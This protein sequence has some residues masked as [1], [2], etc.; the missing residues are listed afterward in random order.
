MNLSEQNH[1]GGVLKKLLIFSILFAGTACSAHDIKRFVY[2][3]GK[4]YACNEN[5]PN[6]P[7]KVQECTDREL[8][9]E[10]YKAAR[11]ETLA[12]K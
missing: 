9:Y 11:E 7:D 8:S 4:H 12:D 6:L 10:E 1:P 2:D 5:E 3:I